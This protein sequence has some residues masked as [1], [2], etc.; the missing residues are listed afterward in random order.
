[1][2]AVVDQEVDV[3]AQHGLVNGAVR[4]E[5]GRD[6]SEDAAQLLAHGL[7][8][9][10]VVV[11]GALPAMVERS[12]LDFSLPLIDDC[13]QGYDSA[14]RERFASCNDA[15]SLALLSTIHTPVE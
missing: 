9:F 13:R 1:M 10:G 3:A 15:P 8:S 2:Q 14:S 7:G 11:R 12:A 4:G 6:G 5:R